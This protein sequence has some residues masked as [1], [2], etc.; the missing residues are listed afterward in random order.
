MEVNSNEVS[1]LLIKCVHDCRRGR[2]EVT[3]TA[4]MLL[5]LFSLTLGTNIFLYF[6]FLQ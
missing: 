5:Y 1:Q 2:E 4:N 3:L 6:I